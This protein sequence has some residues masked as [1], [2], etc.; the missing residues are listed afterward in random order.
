MSLLKSVIR[1]SKRSQ[2]RCSLK[3]DEYNRTQAHSSLLE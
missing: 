1:L 2:Q 3:H